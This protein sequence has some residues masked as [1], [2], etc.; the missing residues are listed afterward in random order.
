MKKKCNISLFLKTCHGCL[1]LN[2][3]GENGCLRLNF[4]I[5]DV[6]LSR[7][8]DTLSGTL[9]ELILPSVKKASSVKCSVTWVDLSLFDIEYLG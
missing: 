5:C 9:D 4:D 8:V 3:V 7:A 2:G 6:L 1:L